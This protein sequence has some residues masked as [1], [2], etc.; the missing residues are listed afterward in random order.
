MPHKN[1][2]DEINEE[3]DNDQFE[4]TQDLSI[5]PICTFG[6]LTDV[7]YADVDDG[8]SYDQKVRGIN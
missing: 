5:R 2:H 6:L 8:K 1:E 7:Q 3:K 4:E